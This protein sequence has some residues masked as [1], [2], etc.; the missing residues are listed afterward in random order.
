MQYET[1]RAYIRQYNIDINNPCAYDFN[2]VVHLLL[3]ALDNLRE[4]ALEEEL[5][6]IGHTMTN[7]QR[8]FL[9]KIADFG[10]AVMDEEIEAES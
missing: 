6:S 9:K 8:F 1:M 7:E 10:C 2:G 4:H 5:E 3:A